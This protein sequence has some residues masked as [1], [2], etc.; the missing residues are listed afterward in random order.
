MFAFTMAGALALA[1]SAAAAPITDAQ[2]TAILTKAG[3]TICHSVDKKLVGPSYLEVAKKHKG[4]KTAPATLP[5]K[6]RKGGTG[7]YG[8][9][10][11]PPNPPDK[12]NDAD[13]KA[14]VE[15]ILSKA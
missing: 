8:A 12:I 11:M 9:I 5:D 2:A 15:W 13:L 6:I 1:S 14:L 7:V 3:C 10:P 4:D